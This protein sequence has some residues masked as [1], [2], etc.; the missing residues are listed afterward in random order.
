MQEA[1]IDLSSL[2]GLVK[3]WRA[4]RRTVSDITAGGALHEGLSPAPGRSADTAVS[5]CG[6]DPPRTHSK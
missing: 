2:A 4:K 6:A 5:R 1:R 3:I